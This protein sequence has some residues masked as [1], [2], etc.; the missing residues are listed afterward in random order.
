MLIQCSKEGLND[1][2]SLR[3]SA[4]TGVAIRFSSLPLGEGGSHVSRKCE[5]DEG[6]K[7]I[8]NWNP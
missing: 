1:V 8:L 7:G 3:A 6:R 2:M 4:H 5:T